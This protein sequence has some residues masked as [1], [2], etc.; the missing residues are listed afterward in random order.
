M[1]TTIMLISAA[2]SSGALAVPYPVVDT[3][4][5]FA[6]GNDKGQDA[7]YSANAPSYKDNGDGTVTDQVTGLMWTQDPGRKMTFDDA[8]KN[9][10][11]CKTG[12]HSDW[13]LPTIKELY[14]LIQLN[15]TDPDPMRTDTTG[16]KPFI[17]D[18][19][20]K[21]T[22]GKEEDGDRIIDSQF[23]TSTK[24]VSTTMRGAETMFGVNF[25]DGRI[26]GYGI[27]DPRGRG[28]KTFYVLYVRGASDY[29][30]N[31]FKNNGDGT[32]TDEA[33]GLTWMKADSGKGLDWPSALEYAEGMEFAG[34]SDWRLPNA[35]E[36][37]SIIDYTRSPDTTDSAAIDPVFQCSEIT[38]EGGKKDYAHYWSSSTH[39]GSRSTDT[40]VYFAFGRSL[41]FM[42]DR[43]TGEY[44]LLDVHGAGSQRSDPKVG[45]A[46]RFPHG[47]GPQGD[48][49]RIENMVR[50]VRGG[51]VTAVDAP[52]AKEPTRQKRGKPD[53][54]PSQ[55]RGQRQSMTTG[56]RG[57]GTQTARSSQNS[58]PR[59]KV[60]ARDTEF[61]EKFPIGSALPD[62]LKLYDT[63]RKLVAAN[64][65]FDA[66]YTVVVG[67]C[68][69]CPE[70]RNSYP[71][72]EAVAADY[73][74]KGVQ[75][76]FLYQSLTH[77]ENWG[78][79]QPTSIQERFAQVEHAKEL[80]Q[81]TIPWLTDTMENEMKQYF[82]MTPNSQFVFDRDG[83]IVHRDSWGRGSSLRESL[84][85]LVGPSDKIT[86]T[87]DLNLPKFGRHKTSTANMLIEP[88]RLDGVAVPLRVAAGGEEANRK[89][90]QSRAYGEANRY[91]KLRPEA[92]QELMRTGTGQLYLGFRQDPVLGAAWNNLA[93][94]PRYRIIA[95]GVK[96]TPA[97]AAAPK[98]SVES[99]TEPREFLV[100]VK[101][102]KAGKPI[103][104]QLQYFACNKEKGW[105]E[106]VEQ[107]FTVWLEKDETAGMVSGRT[108]FPGNSR[109]GQA[110]R[111]KQG[112]LGQRQGKQGGSFMERSDQNRDGK[113]SKDEFRGPA[114]RFDRFDKNNDGYISEDEAPTGRP[115]QNRNK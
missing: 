93:T 47:R 34:H 20:F 81:T 68:L 91:A 90:I 43:R 27:E 61:K 3:G 30:V 29:G 83:K 108:H 37:Q 63:N 17:D 92:D 113:V 111:G 103:K 104:V 2:L 53:Q 48:V 97:M 51:D 15:G 87:A 86:T 41:G 5:T 36:L 28:K 105:C 69:T 35:K 70:Y 16:L 106:A 44:T 64:S 71:E 46:S 42:Q 66:D 115:G 25:A 74:D 10:S 60:R 77:P 72:I 8:V 38:N 45:D 58:R 67:G 76:Y 56:Q 18:S 88:K 50:L 33:T 32:I 84:A 9:A 73:R 100:D 23:A 19:I 107:E 94:P 89:E 65:I 99:D 79:V 4:Q 102:W 26:K 31:K 96:V 112:Q 14:S 59:D 75:F 40:A 85:N 62:S 12:G 95:S 98:L 78:F 52:V 80:L 55:A 49:I 11:K 24:Y 13:R 7:H 21:F 114:D 22:Y 54:Q 6:Y 57:G 110:E 101:N 82:A 1:K 109:G 39:I